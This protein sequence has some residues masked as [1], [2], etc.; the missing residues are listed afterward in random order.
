MT[1]LGRVIIVMVAMR[2]LRCCLNQNQSQFLHVAKAAW[3][4]PFSAKRYW[5]QTAAVTIMI[6]QIFTF[7]IV[8]TVITIVTMV[9]TSNSNKP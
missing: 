8:I 9:I 6:S 3:R 7:S 2:F 5:N 1:V 4:Y